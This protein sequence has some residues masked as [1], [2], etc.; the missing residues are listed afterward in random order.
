MEQIDRVAIA[1]LKKRY[2]HSRFY[3]EYLPSLGIQTTKEGKNAYI[4]L[5]EAE[6]LEKYHEVRGK[7]KETVAEFLAGLKHLPQT[8]E[9]VSTR[10]ETRYDLS[11]YI[12]HVEL[13]KLAGTLQQVNPV[14]R[15]MITG[16]ILQTV[17]MQ[18][19]VIIRSVLLVLLDREKLPRLKRFK[20]R[21]FEFWR[22]DNKSSEEWLAE[23]VESF[24]S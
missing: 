19:I 20:A 7:G 14:A 12:S 21:G 16:W 4:T 23:M 2:G 10:A 22:V 17:A 11:H 8:I 18:Q 15:W 24:N 3:G 6:L 13:V 1:P 9:H 5:H